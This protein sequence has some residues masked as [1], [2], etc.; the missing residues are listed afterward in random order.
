M[1]CFEHHQHISPKDSEVLDLNRESVA[2]LVVQWDAKDGFNDRIRR[3]FGGVRNAAEIAVEGFA[4]LIIPELT[5]YIL[6]E[7]ANIG[8]G[9]DYW[10][11][12]NADPDAYD[13]ENREARLEVSGTVEQS[14]LSGIEY[15]VRQK[16]EQTQKSDYT[17]LP[18]YILIAEFS[19]PIIYLEKR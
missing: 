5:G 16:M 4:H 1:I 11:T 14:Y 7:R 8:D 6:L 17:G 19:R 13:F 9:V 15:I 10:M 12:S 18:A 3:S 2:S